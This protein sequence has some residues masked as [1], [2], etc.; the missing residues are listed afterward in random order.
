MLTRRKNVDCRHYNLTEKVKADISLDLPSDVGVAMKL[1]S[2]LVDVSS[3][4]ILF[5]HSVAS[6]ALFYKV[7]KRKDAVVQNGKY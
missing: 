6:S 3:P 4:T 7:H 2:G 5:P 1:K